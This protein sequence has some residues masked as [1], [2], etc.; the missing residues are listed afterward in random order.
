MAVNTFTN[1]NEII[2]SDSFNHRI[3]V[4]NSENSETIKVIA[5]ENGKSSRLDGEFNNP[6]GI[7]IDEMQSHLIITDSGN[8][9]IQIF[10]LVNYQ[11]KFKFGKYGTHKGE[12][13]KPIGVARD[14]RSQIYVCDRDNH[15]IQVF[16]HH[17][18][19]LTDWGSFGIGNAQFR[20]PEY[21]YV[22]PIN[23]LLV[24]DT[25]NHRIQIFNLNNLDTN[26]TK[27]GVFLSSF[28]AFG[29]EPGFFN[30]P[31][32]IT[33][34]ND[35]FIM[36]SDSKNNRLQLFEPNGDFVR[37]IN[38]KC[39]DEFNYNIS[40]DKPVAIYATN[41]GGLLITEWGRSHKLQIF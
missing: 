33:T 13:H 10:D 24:S 1:N 36:V 19:W 17:G 7:C 38:E 6:R 3:V 14:L 16:N 27:Y 41:N 31:R 15:R 26:S 37:E 11:Y 35:G 12:F 28:G 4:R 8:H 25:G 9:R 22:S 34:D 23:Y 39:S 21:L 20:Y 40:F 5:S 30:V 18:V 32:G 29:D 2:V